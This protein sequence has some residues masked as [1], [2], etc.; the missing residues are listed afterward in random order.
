MQFTSL[1][2]IKGTG[3][4]PSVV[5]TVVSDVHN[6]SSCTL[7]VLFCSKRNQEFVKALVFIDSVSP[8]IQTNLVIAIQKV[9]V[10]VACRTF[11]DAQ[12]R[13]NH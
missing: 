12:P 4:R 8:Q 2:R 5:D 9:R 1:W 10:D 7:K 6:Y 3:R 11:S 13:L